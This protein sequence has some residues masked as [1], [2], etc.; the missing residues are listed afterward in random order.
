MSC[1]VRLVSVLRH[2]ARAAAV[3]LEVVAA[4]LMSLHVASHTEG[5][6]TPGVGA[7]EGL[8]ASVRVTVYT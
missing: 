8:L 7:L 5:L 1:H 2:Q 4:T 3:A 6:A